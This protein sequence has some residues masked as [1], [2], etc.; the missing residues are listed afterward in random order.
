MPAAPITLLIMISMVERKQWVVAVVFVDCNND[1]YYSEASTAVV[2]DMTEGRQQSFQQ[3]VD[4]SSL[5]V[6]ASSSSCFHL[7]HTMLAAGDAVVLACHLLYN[8]FLAPHSL[9]LPAAQIVQ[10]PVLLLD[11]AA[12]LFS[13]HQAHVVWIF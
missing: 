1:D 3:E 7:L 11:P 10:I 2:V 4:T 5:L 13:F 12:A 9:A 6:L 8:S